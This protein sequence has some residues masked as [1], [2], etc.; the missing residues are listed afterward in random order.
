MVLGRLPVMVHPTVRGLGGVVQGAL[1]GV[2]RLRTTAAALL[3]RHARIVPLLLVWSAGARSLLQGWE[4]GARALIL[5]EVTVAEALL[6]QLGLIVALD[7]ALMWLEVFVRT[8]WACRSSKL[9]RAF[10]LGRLMGKLMPIRHHGNLV[11]PPAHLWS[12][13]LVWMWI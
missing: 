6:M 1:G 7:D 9:A 11:I 8:V 5:G 4:S 13:I 10:P 3:A 12:T 2:L